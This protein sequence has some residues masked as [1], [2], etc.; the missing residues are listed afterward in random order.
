MDFSGRREKLRKLLKK[1]GAEALLATSAPNVTYLTG[2]TGDSSY[3]LL[4]QENQILISDGRYLTQIGEECPGLETNIRRA[5]ILI[6]QQV[7]RVL[8]GTRISRLAIEADSMT[9]A[10]R[11][12][13]AEKLPKLEIGATTG[14]VEHLRQVKDKE[15]LA[16]IRQ[17]AKIAEKSFAVI[18]AG[19]RPE[20]TE[21]QIGDALEHQFRLFGGDG[22]AFDPIVA[23]GPRGALPHAKLTD[24][25][26]GN[27]DILLV[28]WGAQWRLYKS[29]L[30]RVL[31]T[32]KI[33]AKLRRVYEVVLSAQ[34]RA[35]AAIRPGVPTTEVDA[36]A[37]SV[38][39]EAGLGHRFN[40]GIGHGFGLEIHESPRMSGKNTAAL[41]PGMVV[42]VEPGVYL[43]GWG[44]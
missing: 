31:V 9:V 20:Q 40:H 15:E 19:L 18:R 22:P 13:I 38:I 28:D 32:G 26:V 7:T 29:D 8:R 2:F 34:A 5:G 16:R 24:R 6:H 1:Y 17:A 41:K 4:T 27:G 11:E 39:A 23:V 25:R 21:K 12:R 42:T 3:L 33:S 44:G 14:M 30:T 35:I 36:A 43:P 10:T 37:R